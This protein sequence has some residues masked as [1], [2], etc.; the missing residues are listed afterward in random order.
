MASLIGINGQQPF[1]LVFTH[2]LS[3][4]PAFALFA[5]TMLKYFVPAL[6]TKK[7]NYLAVALIVTGTTIA[8]GILFLL[9]NHFVFYGIFWP[10]ALAPEKWF[11]FNLFIQSLLPVW[12][13]SMFLVTRKFTSEWLKESK[14]KT[15]LEKENLQTE[16]K[17]LKNQ[18][19][20]HFLFNT[21]NNLYTLALMKSDKTPEMISRL[22]DM[23][24][25]ILYEC[26]TPVI[27][28]KKEMN[29]INN[30]VKLQ[31]LRYGDRLD[32]S[33]QIDVGVDNFRIA[34]MILF[35]FVENCFK[36]GSGSDPGIPWIKL[37]FERKGDKLL[38]IAE[39]S[40]PGNSQSH[41]AEKK[42][43]GLSNMQKRLELLYSGHYKLDINENNKVYKAELLMEEL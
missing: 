36:H 7:R 41:K 13:P 12:I 29:L 5:Y 23:F 2:Y 33:I 30:Y 20:P 43:I 34:P 14:A 42:G 17:M 35:T 26:N 28:L 31:Q 19:N 25:F 37:S 3:G 6:L 8:S 24:Q 32:Y 11:S 4:I 10:H 1:W 21:L 27:T 38:F 40:K 16:L 39:N 22:S 9:L 18:L 15:E